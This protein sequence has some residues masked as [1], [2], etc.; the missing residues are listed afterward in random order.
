MSSARSR[1]PRVG[2]RLVAV[3]LAV[4]FISAH[5]IAVAPE[6]RAD[7]TEWIPP[8]P[9]S[10]VV[11]FHEPVSRYGAGHRG[12]DFAA[13]SGS[14]VRASNAGT[15]VFAG[16]VAGAQHVVVL[17]AGGIRTSYSFLQR[18][19]I[20]TGQRVQRGQVVGASGGTGDGHGP[21]VLH[22]GV[23]IGDRYVDPMLL[24]RP[25]DLTEM[26]RLVPAPEREAA[27][28][29]SPWEQA[30]QLLGH[31]SGGGL[32]DDVIDAGGDLIDG[33][34]DLG[35]AG[36]DT[37]ID[38]IDWAADETAEH[39]EA[40][41]DFLVEAGGE[42]GE[43]I[44]DRADDLRA[45]VVALEKG[46]VDVV[47][48]N[49]QAWVDVAAAI[50]DIGADIAEHL[51][52]CPQPPA[53][54]HPPESN[55][56]VVAVGGRDSSRRQRKDGSVTR[57]FDFESRKL[58]YRGANVAYFSYDRD[59]PTYEAA[60][61]HGDLH[62]QARQL[63]RQIQEQAAAHPNQPMDL[64]GHSQGGVVIALFLQEVHR[65]HEDE[66]PPIKNVVTFASPLQGTPAANL[67]VTAD[68]SGLK[69]LVPGGLAHFH[70]RT[71]AMRQ[72]CEGSPTVDRLW[73]RNV[74]EDIRFL[75]IAGMEDL[76]VPS[77]STVAPGGTSIV[78]Q[79]GDAFVPDDHGAILNDDDAISAAQTHLRGDT[80][81]GCGPFAGAWGHGWGVVV[82]VM[83]TAV[84]GAQNHV[85][86]PVASP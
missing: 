77:P 32:L 10:V 73:K 44:E 41:Y 56:L 61:T 23:R 86:A 67:G 21:G 57:S 28:T 85:E 52:A 4:T 68:G 14:A 53:Q 58:G 63:G 42:I 16:S 17:H 59:G 83:T 76:W 62:E 64:V 54:Q 66:Y 20:S 29:L 2:R 24:F 48:R 40:G 37:V 31:S 71:E 15:V 49:L 74:P 50:V 34:V 7:S 39:F 25:R 60:D 27:A 26:V 65:G 11:P 35:E 8:V 72:L 30:R 13:A 81:A 9:G 6:V 84:D 70:L 80:P 82:R 19:D 22:F 47:E 18:I 78:V 12:V 75:S 36:A 43:F 79:A 1:G 38:G 45:T 55:H 51:F 33:A 46:I 5:L 69:A 3:A